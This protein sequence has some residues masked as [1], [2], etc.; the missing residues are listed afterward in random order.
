MKNRLSMRNC[1]FNLSWHLILLLHVRCSNVSSIT[2]RT[3]L[4]YYTFD[5]QLLLLYGSLYHENNMCSLIHSNTHLLTEPSERISIDVG[6]KSAQFSTPCQFL[7]FPS[8]LFGLTWTNP[9]RLS[10]AK[11]ILTNLRM[12]GVAGCWSGRHKELQWRWW[13]VR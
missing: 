4:F 8:V 9:K 11:N 10:L 12:K 1:F 13:K 3:L 6:E 5:A 2:A 7:Y